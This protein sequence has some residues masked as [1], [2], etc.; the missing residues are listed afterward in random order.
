M[1]AFDMGADQQRAEVPCWIRLQA[2]LVQHLVS[3][4]LPPEAHQQEAKTCNWYLEVKC[5]ELRS[6]AE[7][8]SPQA[9]DW[10]SIPLLETPKPDP[11]TFLRRGHSKTLPLEKKLNPEEQPLKQFSPTT[12]SQDLLPPKAKIETTH[13]EGPGNK[14]RAFSVVVPP[15]WNALPLEFRTALPC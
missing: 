12:S 8:P 7:P 15:L 4:R 6:S 1:V 9:T 10:S 13:R 11:Q 2:H 14:G 5:A 3:H